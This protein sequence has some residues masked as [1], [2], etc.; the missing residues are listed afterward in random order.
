ME[1]KLT[2]EE[3][4]KV[5][6]LYLGCDYHVCYNIEGAQ[7]IEKVTGKIIQ[8]ILE[9]AWLGENNRELLLLTPLE[10]ISDEDYKN[11]VIICGFLDAV[12]YI[13]DRDFLTGDQ[14]QNWEVMEYLKQ[15][16]YATPL[17]FGVNHWANSK[18]AIELG[19]AIKR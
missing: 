14:L 7:V 10:L 9:D 17:F 15:R 18:T 19:I 13:T 2:N 4:A 16:G 8:D 12:Q 6:A 1:N 11:L 3:I 5:F